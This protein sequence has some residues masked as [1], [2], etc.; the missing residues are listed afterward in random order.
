MAVESSFAIVWHYFRIW[1]RFI[2]MNFRTVTTSWLEFACYVMAKLLRMG[3]FFVFVYALFRNTES[4]VGYSKGEVLLFFAVMNTV[5]IAFQLIARGLTT[6]PS[7]VR[8]GEYDILLSKPVSPFFASCFKMFDFLD[9]TTVPAAIAFL[10]IAIHALPYSVTPQHVLIAV[11]CWFCS[12]VMAVSLNVIIASLA[13]WFTEIE[14]GFWIYRDLVYVGRFPPEIYTSSIRTIFTYLIP[15]LLIV[16]TPAKALMGQAS[17]GL[18]ATG[19]IVTVLLVLAARIT[20]QKALR[21]YAS[22]SA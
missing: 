16:S 15:I 13:F 5:D 18:V 6:I 1:R 12:L 10:G 9:L 7:M 19:F 3:F 20:W 4:L 2:V 14:N 11:V 8:R 22:A 21:R 17:F